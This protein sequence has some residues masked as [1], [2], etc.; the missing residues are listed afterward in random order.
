MNIEESIQQINEL[1]EAW[2]LNEACLNQTDIDA[3]KCLLKQNKELK[4]KYLN[5]VADYETTMFEKEQ[6]NSLVNSCQEEIRQLKKQLE[7]Y[8]QELEKADSITQSC[9]FNGKEESKISYRKCL[10]ILNK[11]EAQQKEF[12]DY[13]NKTIEE[14][15]CDDVDD[16]EMK[17][18]LIQRID[19]FKEILSKYKEIIGSDINVGSIGGKE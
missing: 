15:E 10:N 17:D 3:I 1:I 19:I 6:L 5:A 18:Y 14:L 12:I 11:K 9:I 4:Q 2:E 7:E 8:Q 16:E 13:M